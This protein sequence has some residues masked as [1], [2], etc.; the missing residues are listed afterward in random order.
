[1]VD[2]TTIAIVPPTLVVAYVIFGIAGFGTALVAAPVLAHAMPIAS[3]VPLLALL[4]FGAAALNGFQLSDK[5]AKA[6]LVWLAPLMI[7]GSIVGVTLLISLP[8]TLMMFLLGV[9]AAGYGIHSLFAPPAEQKI[10]KQWVG[11]F[12]PLGGIFSAM[13]G[14]GGFVYAIYL[15]RRLDD[16]DAI[17]ATQSTLIGMVAAESSRR[18]KAGEVHISFGCQNLRKPIRQAIDTSDAPMSTIQGLMKLEIRN[19]RRAEAYA[20]T[21]GFGAGRLPLTKIPRSSNLRRKPMQQLG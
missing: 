12:G 16:K 21:S 20:H 9:F 17:R 2:W 4:D 11:V 10:G 7:A 13:F 3:V 5:I 15:S 19:C 1:M 6:E 8:G 14:S 18:R